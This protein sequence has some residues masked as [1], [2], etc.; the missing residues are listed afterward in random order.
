MRE[1]TYVEALN[2]GLRQIMEVDERVFLIGQ[3]VNSPWYVGTSTIG[4]YDRFGPQRVIDT[5]VAE[6]T[7]TGT[8]VGAAL[9]GMRPVVMHPRMD[10]MLLAFD[11]LINEAADWHYMFGGRVSVPLTVWSIIN[12]GGE[13]AA[14]HSKAL[15]AM[16]A[17]VPGL[18]VAMPSTPYDV[19]GLLFSCLEQA[20]PVIFI[21]ERWLY[22]LKGEVPEKPYSIPVGKAVVRRTG[23]DVTIVAT[24]Y[25]VPESCQ[26]AEALAEAGIE[27]EVIDVRWL[28]PL[29]TDTIIASVRKTGRLVVADSGWRTCG[30]AAEIIA[31]V[32]EQVFDSLASAPRR[33]TLPDAPAPASSSLEKAYY[34]RAGA[35]VEAVQQVCNVKDEAS[36]AAGV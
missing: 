21:D 26:A 14:Q 2:E 1:I 27:A 24:S 15:Q 5:P 12:R 11:Q 25:M 28:T 33:V 19:K 23:T 4:L 34:P 31:R 20:D 17:H 10:F 32:S 36:L 8:A 18:K 3:G 16:M 7:V 13:Q 22:N 6:N 29:D 30:F 35:V 9:A